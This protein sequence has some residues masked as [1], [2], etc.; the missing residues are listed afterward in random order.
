MGSS[1][2]VQSATKLNLL[3]TQ[4]VIHYIIKTCD[5]VEQRITKRFSVKYINF[6]G[7]ILDLN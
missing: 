5:D 3:L 4:S 7:N 6:N 1:T 2:V